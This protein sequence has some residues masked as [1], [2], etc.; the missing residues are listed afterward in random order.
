MALSLRGYDVFASSE[1]TRFLNAADPDRRLIIVQ[2]I[3]G[4]DGF[5]TVVPVTNDLYYARRPTIAIPKSDTW[6][7]S[8]I[9]GMNS[10][11]R[12]TA[13]ALG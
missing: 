9:F 10:R 3:G 13:A 4:N 6:P 8:D 7:V 11:Y 1:S 5:N 2:L 12:P